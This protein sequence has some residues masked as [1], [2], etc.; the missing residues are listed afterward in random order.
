M[1]ELQQVDKNGNPNVSVQV[2]F[3]QSHLSTLLIQWA[4][5]GITLVLVLFVVAVNLALS[6]TERATSATC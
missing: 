3:P 5:V 2:D 4:L 1:V 6:A